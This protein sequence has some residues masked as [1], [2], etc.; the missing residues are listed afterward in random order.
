MDTTR[1]T[2]KSNTRKGN[3]DLQACV[4]GPDV[5]IELSSE[6]FMG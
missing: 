2:M 3:I 1:V 4:H 5:A 6:R